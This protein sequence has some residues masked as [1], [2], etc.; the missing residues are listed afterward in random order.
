MKIHPKVTSGNKRSK[1]KNEHSI[2]LMDPN[3]KYLEF[4][5]LFQTV[6]QLKSITI[7]SSTNNE[8]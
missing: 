7:L 3:M 5:I 1:V 6:A 2:L 4:K 8:E